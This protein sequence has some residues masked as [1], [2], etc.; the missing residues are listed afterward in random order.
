M[1]LDIFTDSPELL[2]KEWSLAKLYDAYTQKWLKHEAM[3]PTS[4]LRW[5][6]KAALIEEIAWSIYIMKAPFSYLYTD[7]LYQ[8]VIF[9]RTEL[10]NILYS[11]ASK[12]QSVSV[13]LLIDDICLRTFLIGDHGN[14]YYFIHKS[15]QEYYAA[16]HILSCMSNNADF[17]AQSI[18]EFMQVEISTFLR[19]MLISNYLTLPQRDLIT[20]NLIEAFRK[21][22]GDDYHSVTIRDHA[23]FYLAYL[24]TRRAVQFLEDAHKRERNKDVQRAIVVGLATFCDRLDILEQ[25]I[26]TLYRDSEAAPINTGY[27][28]VYYG[29]QPLEDG[30]CDKGGKKCDATIGALIHHLGNNRYRNRWVLDLFTLRYLLVSRGEVAFLTNTKDLLLLKDFFNKDFRN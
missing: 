18:R 8:N 29:D 25:Y 23:S 9:T 21:H 12:Y 13:N 7:S 28:L 11:H 24:R 17:A 27:H 10:S 20:N 15:F 1:I 30:Y 26:G 4:V 22:G 5:H 14:Y 16:K 2:E 6:E 3:K 19:G